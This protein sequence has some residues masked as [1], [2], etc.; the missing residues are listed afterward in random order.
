MDIRWELLVFNWART[1]TI[2]RFGWFAIV[3]LANRLLY[4]FAKVF[5]PTF[6]FCGFSNIS[7][8]TVN[9]SCIWQ[10]TSSK[11]GSNHEYLAVT[12]NSGF[13]TYSILYLL[14][15]LFL[16]ST[17]KRLVSA[18]FPWNNVCISYIFVHRSIDRDTCCRSLLSYN[19]MVK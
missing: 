15:H 13:S 3:L 14:G 8:S 17:Y 9:I 12:L 7:H 11:H 10:W 5:P 19:C 16:R 1:Y 18:A 6:H 2:K 4:P